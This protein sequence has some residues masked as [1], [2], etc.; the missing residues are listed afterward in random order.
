MILESNAT[1]EDFVY[2]NISTISSVSDKSSHLEPMISLSVV[3]DTSNK[4]ECSK[5]NNRNR[6]LVDRRK[7]NRGCSQRKSYTVDVKKRAIELRDGGMSVGNVAKMLHT[8][9][10]NVEK[11]CS[12]KVTT[13]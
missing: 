10:S 11:W 7:R 3:T 2:E 5:G 4:N 6:P 1:F 13:T 9:K 8:A 12:V